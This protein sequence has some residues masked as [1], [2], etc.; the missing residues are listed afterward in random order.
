MQN[1]NNYPLDQPIYMETLDGLSRDESKTLLESYI[2][3]QQSFLDES[4]ITGFR[5]YQREVCLL[6]AQLLHKFLFG[7]TDITSQ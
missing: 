6:G 4:P 2:H 3:R 1:N 7:K 5:R